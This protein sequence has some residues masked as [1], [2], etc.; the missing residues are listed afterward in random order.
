VLTG[1]L[2]ITRR[3]LVDLLTEMWLNVL[4]AM[5]PGAPSGSD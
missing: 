1:R 2:R 4:A 5:Q 3:Q